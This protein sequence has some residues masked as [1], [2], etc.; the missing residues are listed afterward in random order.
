MA[1]KCML[2]ATTNPSVFRQIISLKACCILSERN[3]H[4]VSVG[5][6]LF[7]LLQYVT[8]YHVYVSTHPYNYFPIL[9]SEVAYSVVWG[10]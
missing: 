2:V 10:L 9:G 8:Y 6:T 1:K 4:F 3:L 7:M 5:L